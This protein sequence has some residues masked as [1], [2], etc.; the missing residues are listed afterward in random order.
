MKDKEMRLTPT[1]ADLLHGNRKGS[2][3]NTG[4]K[5]THLGTVGL[6]ILW[7]RKENCVEVENSICTF[8]SCSLRT[9]NA[10]DLLINLFTFS[11]G[12]WADILVNMLTPGSF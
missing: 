3:M 11:S 9:V 12:L 1:L 5:T 10:G 2:N 6:R 7:D 4:V 8:V